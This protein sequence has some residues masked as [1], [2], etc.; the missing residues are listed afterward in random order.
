MG[1]VAN[2]RKIR[3]RRAKAAAENAASANRLAFGRGKDERRRSE[4]EKA[5][6]E[7]SLDAHRLQA[8]RRGD[9]D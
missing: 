6:A 2:L 5:A 3:K 9:D 1:E 8:P 4:L 7:R